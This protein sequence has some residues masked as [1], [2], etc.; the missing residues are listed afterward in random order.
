M[1]STGVGFGSNL[2]EPGAQDLRANSL[3]FAAVNMQVKLGS[4]EG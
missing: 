4:G 3:A 2:A 1:R